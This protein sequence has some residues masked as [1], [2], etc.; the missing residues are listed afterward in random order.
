MEPHMS[1]PSPCLNSGN[2]EVEPLETGVDTHT[3][4]LG[5]AR[6]EGLN[7]YQKSLRNKRKKDRKSSAKRAREKDKSRKIKNEYLA[8]D[9]GRETL[10]KN[11]LK[12]L[13]ESPRNDQ[14]VRKK[15]RKKAG[16][17]ERMYVACV[18]P[19]VCMTT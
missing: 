9:W 19:C 10:L 7:R 12:S 1:S 11:N 3:V 4:P 14:N 2:C 18:C 13:R 16:G 15:E 17:R 5:G 8:L 6:V